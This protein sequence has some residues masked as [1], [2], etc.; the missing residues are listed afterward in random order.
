M[1]GRLPQLAAFQSIHND[2]ID[3]L[4]GTILRI[5]AEAS[6]G[7]ADNV[8]LCID[9]IVD[10]GPSSVTDADMTN[11]TSALQGIIACLQNF[12]TG[13][14]PVGTKVATFVGRYI[15]ALVAAAKCDVSTPPSGLLAARSEVAA[16]LEGWQEALQHDEIKDSIVATVLSQMRFDADDELRS[17]VVTA[18]ARL[19]ILMDRWANEKLTAWRKIKSKNKI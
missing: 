2:R 10:H 4:K 5:Y 1:A 11:A 16:L 9:K 13:H 18:K 19:T 12:Y 8:K 7:V 3:L 14:A 6:L 17:Q 15:G